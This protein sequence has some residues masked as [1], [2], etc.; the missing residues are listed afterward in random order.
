MRSLSIYYCTAFDVPAPYS[1][2]ISFDFESI[3]NLLQVN[4]Q[5][6]YSHREELTEDEILNEGFTN[7]DN[8]N[9]KGVLNKVWEHELEMILAKTEL[10]NTSKE[11]EIILKTPEG[12]FI[13]KNFKEWSV[14]I[15]DLVQAVFETSAKEKLWQMDILFIK[16]GFQ[17]LKQKLQISFAN[18]TVDF[19]FGSKV[20]LDW[21]QAKKLMELI[22]L[23]D[24]DEEKANLQLPVNDGVYLCFDDKIW[25]KLGQSIMNP[26]GNKG[27][28]A[29]LEKELSS[30]V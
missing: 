5:M 16:N 7:N 22:Y 12:E 13:P 28:L 29:K 19:A 26:Y 1:Y 18:R 2:E 25:Y 24:F 20:I 10:K 6:E 9:W 14:L 27:Y 23:A 3:N 17:N 21:Q 30:L 4:F 15:Q 11:H 8:F